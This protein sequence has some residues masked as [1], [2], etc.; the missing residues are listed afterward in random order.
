MLRKMIKSNKLKIVLG[1]YLLILAVCFV[2]GFFFKSNDNVVPTT[3]LEIV[4]KVQ[5]T[6]SFQNFIWCFTNN[7]AILFITFWVNYWTWGT[8][9]IIWCASS[10]FILGSVTKFSVAL[11][12]W[13][14]PVFISLELMASIIILLSSTY[15]RF[16]KNIEKGERQ[17]G[18]IITLIVVTLIL[19]IVAILETIVLNSMR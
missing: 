17:R 11:N 16:E 10:T 13:I 4:T 12:L 14:V 7:F 19:I 6:N 18:I 1:I 5:T 2:L 8:I 15:Y 9:G 3:L